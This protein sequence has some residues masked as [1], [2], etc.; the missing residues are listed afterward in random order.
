VGAANSLQELPFI[1]QERAAR[2][3][4]TYD[5]FYPS[6]HLTYNF[7]EKLQARAAFAKTYGRPNFSFIIPSVTV[8]EFTDPEDDSVV[9][10]GR[11]NM[12]NPGLLPWAA[13]NYDLTLEY[14]TNQGGMFSAGVF[15]KEV[16]NFFGNVDRPSTAQELEEVGVD[17]STDDW[18]TRTTVNIGAATIDGME[19]SFNQSLAALDPWLWGW[20]SS[21]RLFGNITKIKIGGARQGDFQ[22]FLPTSANWGV[23]FSKKRVRASFRWNHSSD[24]PGAAV[25]NLGPNGENYNAELTQLD[26]NA[27]YSLRPNLAL[28]INM[29]N[30]LREFRIQSLRSDLYPEYAEARYPNL[31]NGIA[32]EFGIRGSF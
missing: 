2:S 25:T 4:R 17:P 20:G 8:N 1:W 6:V 28:F 11:L 18:I 3:N 10:G 7:T 32:T 26:V 24:R 29:K 22:G 30:V 16:A 5:G 19:L 12:R 23:Y 15:R 14:Y 27:S 9:T 13:D 31:L 21:L